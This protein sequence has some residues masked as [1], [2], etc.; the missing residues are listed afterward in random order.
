MC[1][2]AVPTIYGIGA[3]GGHAP[4]IKVPSGTLV[5]LEHGLSFE[6]G[7]AISCCVGT[8]YAS[9]RRLRVVSGQTIVIFG[10]GP[11]GL[12]GTQLATALGARVIAVEPSP[13]RRVLARALGADVVLDPNESD[14]VSAIREL[15]SGAG[16]AVALETSGA[17]TARSAAVGALAAWGTLALLGVGG[18]FRPDVRILM[19]QQINVFGLWTFSTDDQARCGEF[20][21]KEGISI[22]RIVTDRCSLEDARD[23]YCLADR[24][25]SGKVVFLR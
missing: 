24:Q 7:A 3:H 12:S 8:V 14:P 1:T 20:A 13:N 21:V 22:E 6:A 16:A 17:T 19:R 23:A 25:V 15:T 5:P 18:S 2:S 10:Q 11:L 4:Y 9:L